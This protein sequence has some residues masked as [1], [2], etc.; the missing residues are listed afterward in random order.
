MKIYFTR[1]GET[2]WNALNKICGLTDI[3]L[4]ERGVMQAKELA[5]KLADKKIDI[6]IASPMKRAQQTAKIVAEKC[7]A[8][9][10]TDERLIEQN[11]GIYEGEDRKCEG[12]LNNKRNFAYKYPQGESMMQVAAR[13]Y[14]LIDEIKEK[15]AGKTVLCVCHG[16]VCRVANTYF[17]DVTNDEYFHYSLENCGLEE[18]F[19]EEC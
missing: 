10:M 12:F 9:I 1:H 15:Y 13:V 16:G 11:Y 3:D 5:E 17:R 2:Q 4:T 14:H 6:I 19:V 18:Y 7:P 8:P